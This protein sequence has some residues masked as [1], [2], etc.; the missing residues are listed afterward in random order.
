MASILA[1]C[2]CC[3]SSSAV[4]STVT[5]RSVSGMNR[6]RALSR[7]V[8]PLP[9]PPE[10]MMFTRRRTQAVRKSSI[11]LVGRLVRQQVVQR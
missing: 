6:E 2:G 4:S 10:M 1:T 5:T 8:F 9:V 3:N 11:G 7:V